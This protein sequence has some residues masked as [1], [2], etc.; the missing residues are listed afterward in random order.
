VIT[1]DLLLRFLEEDDDAKLWGGARE[2]F[3]NAPDCDV[4]AYRFANWL[5]DHS[6][7]ATVV[8]VEMSS[9]F[10]SILGEH[11]FTVVDGIAIDWTARQFY[12]VEGRDTWNIVEDESE[13]PCPLL[14]V[15]PGTYPLPTLTAREIA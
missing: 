14:F 2:D 4:M 8:K 7:I 1:R 13:I 6:G 9:P 11:Y 5:N 10:D 15:W 12:N 3:E